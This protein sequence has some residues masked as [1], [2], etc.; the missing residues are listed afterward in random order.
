MK[1]LSLFVFTAMAISSIATAAIAAPETT[2]QEAIAERGVEVMPFDLKATTHIFTKSKT[3][4]IQQVIAKDVSD[5]PQIRLVRA[6]L[7]EIAGQFAKGDFSGPAHIHGADMPGLAELKQ[8]RPSEI[9]VQYRETKAGAELI[10]STKKP[11][12]VSALH[13]WFDAQLADHGSDAMEGHH[14]SMM[15]P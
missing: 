1:K 4:G 12:L 2:R 7:K 3:G 11:E 14:H 6:H 9:K 15:H 10:Y 8:A 13:E 5:A